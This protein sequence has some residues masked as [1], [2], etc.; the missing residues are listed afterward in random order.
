MISI[1]SW[2]LASSLLTAKAY[3]N[4]FDIHGVVIGEVTSRAALEAALGLRCGDPIR[5]RVRCSSHGT[6]LSSWPSGT[7]LVTAYYRVSSSI[8]EQV[9]IKFHSSEAIQFDSEMRDKFGEPSPSHI[10]VA[11]EKGG[12][13]LYDAENWTNRNGDT[14]TLVPVDIS[15]NGSGY[16]SMEVKKRL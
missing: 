1:A 15:D 6:D 7:I 5:D 4:P 3:P 10:P 11:N 14:V 2:I 13:T 12:M 8:L 9:Y 16:L